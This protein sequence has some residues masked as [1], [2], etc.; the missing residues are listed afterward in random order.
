MWRFAVL[1]FIAVATGI[2]R[3]L[4]QGQRNLYTM[5]R[6]RYY[7][8][9]PDLGWRVVDDGPPRLGLEVLAA[10]AGIMVGLVLAAWIIDRW[11]RLRPW[12]RGLRGALWVASALPLAVPMWAFA[13]GWLPAG[14][15]MTAPAGVAEAPA[16]VVDAALPGLPAGTWVVA[17]HAGTSVTATIDAGGEDFEARFPRVHGSWRGAPAD[18]TQPMAAELWVAAADVDTGIDM[19]S[20][21]AREDY[22]HA[23]KFPRITF[24][25]TR[26]TGATAAAG[27]AVAFRAEGEVGL[28]GRTHPVAVTGTLRAPDAA[29][30]TRLGFAGD[31]PLVLVEA[32]FDLRIADTE[33]AADRGDFGKDTIGVRVNLVLRP[34]HPISSGGME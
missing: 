26:V 14:A 8:P 13:R 20:K 12:R 23:D 31:A 18:L 7:A 19:R 11:A 34:G 29:A 10:I 33:L 16:G 6:T 21:H 3:W 15:Q 24:A 1:P 2:A 5:M 17:E 32:A 4:A 27:G 25:L 9:D 30:R 28:I 22:L